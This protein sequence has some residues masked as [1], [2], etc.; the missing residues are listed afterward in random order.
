MPLAC[1]DS[2]NRSERI[3]QDKCCPNLVL[4]IKVKTLEAA[5]IEKHI[6]LH[7]CM[8]H[9]S[10]SARV[11]H[12]TRAS[13]AR[14]RDGICQRG[15]YRGQIGVVSHIRYGI[16]AIELDCLALGF[17]APPGG[18][19]ALLQHISVKSPLIGI[20]VSVGQKAE[21]LETD[22]RVVHADVQVNGPQTLL[23]VSIAEG[24][25]VDRDIADDILV[26]A[27]LGHGQR[28]PI[29]C[30]SVCRCL[31]ERCPDIVIVGGEDVVV[32]RMNGHL[33]CRFNQEVH[34]G[35]VDRCPRG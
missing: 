18:G 12:P 4:Q 19:A 33:A 5:Q 2:R 1:F 10:T 9:L 28:C 6:V 23:P 32:R 24:D 11:N 27:D 3:D 29:E 35:R 31:R 7:L 16:A 22:H 30:S 13:T 15:P 8:R 17:G 25:K 20:E 21:E 34:R 14:D 26:G